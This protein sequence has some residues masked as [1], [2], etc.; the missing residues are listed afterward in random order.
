MGSTSDQ[1]VFIDFKCASCNVGRPRQVDA[2]KV[3]ER[4][5]RLKY[6][7][8][9]RNRLVLHNCSSPSGYDCHTL[10]YIFSIHDLGQWTIA[11]KG[12]LKDEVTQMI[13]VA[14]ALFDW[15][16]KVDL[17]QDYAEEIRRKYW[18]PDY[19]DNKRLPGWALA[20]HVFGWPKVFG[21]AIMGIPDLSKIV[22]GSSPPTPCGGPEKAD[23]Y[24]HYPLPI[25]MAVSRAIICM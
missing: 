1:Y 5:K 2:K 6:E 12:T 22:P 15:A 23:E 20:A 21:L 8:G 13:E 24:H 9:T 25:E 17:W 11:E 10:D 14:H 19:E 18:I 7:M 4:S 16:S 3:F